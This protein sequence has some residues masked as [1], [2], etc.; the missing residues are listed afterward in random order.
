MSGINQLSSD[1]IVYNY[2]EVAHDWTC[3]CYY[4]SWITQS[5]DEGSS[6]SMTGDPEMLANMVKQVNEDAIRP[7]DRLSDNIFE[8]NSQ[9]QSICVVGGN[10]DQGI[11]MGMKM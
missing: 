1:M 9:T 10:S 2:I 11:D 6:M 5:R 7:E 4:I 8:Y 3:E